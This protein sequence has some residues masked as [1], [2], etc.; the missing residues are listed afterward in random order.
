MLRCLLEITD[1]PGGA[2]LCSGS[3]AA[4]SELYTHTHTHMQDL[5]GSF[6]LL[7]KKKKKTLAAGFEGRALTNKTLSPSCTSTAQMEWTQLHPMADLA[8][9]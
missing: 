8:A 4:N 1:L 7:L 6:K 9:W 5:C 3:F 2:T